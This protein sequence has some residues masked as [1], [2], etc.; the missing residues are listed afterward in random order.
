MINRDSFEL[1][2]FPS[3]SE[4]CDH[5]TLTPEDNKIIVFIKGTFQGLNASTPK[6]GQE[7][8]SSTFGDRLLWKKAQKKDKKNITSDV[9]NSNIPQRR[10][11]STI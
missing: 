3:I 8:P 5:V 2:K 4:W 1:E 11:A 6:G 10:P 9:I 7:Q